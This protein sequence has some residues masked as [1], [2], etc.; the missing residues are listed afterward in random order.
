MS[1]LMSGPNQ[2]SETEMTDSPKVSLHFP[3]WRAGNYYQQNLADGLAKAAHQAIFPTYSGFLF[4]LSINILRHKTRLLHLHWVLSINGATQKSRMGMY[5]F[6]FMFILDILLL[7]C[8]GVRI[9]WTV[10]NLHSHDP[11]FP[12]EDLFSRRFL[13]RHCYRLLAHSTAAAVEIAALYR[14]LPEKIRIVPHGNYEH[15]YLHDASREES[16]DRLKVPEEGKIFLAFGN[17]KPYKGL[18]DLIRA[19]QSEGGPEDSLLLAGKCGN[20]VYL[21]E[22]RKIAGADARIHFHARFIADDEIRYYMAAADV[23][24]FPFK[25]I[26]TSGSLILASGFAKALIA[27]DVP[28][29]REYLDPQGAILFDPLNQAKGLAQAIRQMKNLNTEKMGLLNKA[30]TDRLDWLSIGRKVADYYQ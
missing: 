21:E 8:L 14:C 20:P 25:N 7:R 18:E 16:R 1:F 9:V 29:L 4:P 10:H 5:R 30:V 22:L 17:M 11:L 6:L 26:F 28:T 2:R 12:A 24:V 13:A 23:C 27:P 3:D 15:N 19:F